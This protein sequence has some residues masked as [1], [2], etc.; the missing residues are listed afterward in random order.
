MTQLSEIDIDVLRAPGEP[1]PMF[2]VIRPN[3][4]LTPEVCE[5]VQRQWQ[6]L[7]DKHPELPPAVCLPSGWNIEAVYPPKPPAE[8]ESGS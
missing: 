6:M 3:A 2:V 7:V 5:H 4:P 1:K 8:I